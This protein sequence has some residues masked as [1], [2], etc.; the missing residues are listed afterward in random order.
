MW[1][2]TFAA[3]GAIL[4]FG[5]GC[6]GSASPGDA[7]RE[8]I[9]AYTNSAVEHDAAAYCEHLSTALRTQA[10][11][12]AGRPSHGRRRDLADCAKLVGSAL[13][14]QDAGRTPPRVTGVRVHGERADATMSR[15]LGGIT[16]RTPVRLV[17]EDGAWR[18]AGV[19]DAR[20][21]DGRRVLRVPTG[22]MAPTLKPGQT[23]LADDHAYRA[24]PPAIG[25]VVVFHPP[26]GA[27]TSTCGDDG[28][29]YALARLCAHPTDDASTESF[30]KRIVAGPGDRVAIR[31]GHLL[32]N[33]RRVA[34][35]AIAPCSESGAGCDFPGAITVPRGMYY[36]LGDNRGSSDDSRFFGAVPAGW[37]VGKVA[38]P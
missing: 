14:R 19:G 24:A 32:R 27:D 11:K 26:A 35:D 21:P 2:R 29:G 36:M 37:I 25:D 1:L 8:T 6:G 3:L 4:A 15:P 13:K 5:T 16:A 10:L 28:A 23:V 34:E 17:R 33:G 12:A 18:I 9:E 31:D 22:S 30:V 20:S 7:V 38:T